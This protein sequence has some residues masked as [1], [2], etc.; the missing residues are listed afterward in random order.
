MRTASI[1]ALCAALPAASGAQSLAARID[2]L[3]DGT[4]RMSFAA[5]PGVCGD[6][7]GSVWITDTRR[8]RFDYDGRHPC[9]N[10]PIRVAIGR[11]E[12]QV[13]SVRSRVAGS[14][15]G[16]ADVELGDVAAADA[17]RYLLGLA[18]SLG[19]RS[20]DE[21]VSAAA[22]ADAPGVWP[23]F[24]RLVRDRDAVLQARKN[25]LFWL[26]QS[27]AP[28]IE[29]VRLYDDLESEELREHYAFVMSQ[30]DDAAAV[31][32]L[33]DIAQHDREL[34]VRKRAMFWL[35]QSRDPKAIKFFRDVL[36]R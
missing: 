28:T 30:R 33:I 22:L 12:G 10:G 14:P 31:D 18:R 32:K 2:A 34:D 25:A 3:R 6:G 17:A 11:S 35:G 13:V 24:A 16:A 29:L 36:V 21:A 27:D 7:T 26:G 19:G 9:I 1:I 20:A 4:V 8:G 23:E 15:S 5:R